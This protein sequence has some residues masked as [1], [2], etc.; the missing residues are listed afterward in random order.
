MIR[1]D[2][3]WLAVEPMDMRSGTESALGRV[4]A[5][6]GSARPHHAYV[7]LKRRGDRM[8]TLICD[9]LGIWLAARRLHEGSFARTSIATN[10]A[11][12]REQF[13]AM[14]LGLPWQRTGADAAVLR[15]RMEVFTGR[16]RTAALHGQTRAATSAR[17]PISLPEVPKLAESG[18]AGYETPEGGL[19]KGVLARQR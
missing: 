8:K 12:T 18:V 4:V 1:V 7:F 15:A 14:V 10:T 11:L 5:V 19:T 13:D 9:G 2:A 6:F 16:L 3:I 17:R